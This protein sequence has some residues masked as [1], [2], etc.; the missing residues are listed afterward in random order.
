MINTISYN[1]VNYTDDTI[2][3]AQLARDTALNCRALNVDTMT[4]TVQS[5]SDLSVFTQNAPIFFLRGRSNYAAWRLKSITRE[6]SDLWTLSMQSP[7]GRLAQLPHRGGIYNGVTATSIIGEI[8]SGVGV[9]WLIDT[10]LE[11]VALYGY[12]PY[13]SPSGENGAMSGSAKDNLLK[14]LF[15]LNASLWCN[16]AGMMIVGSLPATA[17]STIDA[18]R[19]YR[20]NARVIYDAPVTSVTVLEHQYISGGE[21]TTLFDGVTTADQTIV[22]R[23]PMSDLSATGFNVLESGANYAIVSAGTG[24]LTGHKYVHTTREVTRSVTTASAPNEVRVEDATLVSITNSSVV[25]DRLADYYSHR[26]R[27]ECDVV[28]G[29]ESPGDVVNIYD[30]YDR[31]MRSACLESISPITVSQTLKGRVSALVGFTPW[32]TQQFEDVHQLIVTSGLVTIPSNATNITAV[33]IGGGNGG[34]SGGDGSPGGASVSYGSHGYELGVAG[35]A[36]A[37]GAGGA[38][39]KILRVTLTPGDYTLTIGSGGL[40]GTANGT[41][42]QPGGSGSDTTLTHQTIGTIYSTANGASASAGYTDPVDGSTYAAEG[43]SGI[44]GGHGGSRLSLDSTNNGQDV[45]YN[46][47]TWSGGVSAGITRQY[48]QDSSVV[49]II[50]YG[51]GGGGAAV[52]NNG[53]DAVVG[54]TA[55]GAKGANAIQPPVVTIPGSGGNGGNGGGGGGGAGVDR[56]YDGWYN[57]Y[58]GGDGGTGSNGGDGVDGCVILYYRVPIV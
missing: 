6:S 18:D 37:G 11:R 41:S 16:P 40:G 32:Q 33:L 46:G 29:F 50:Y 49:R 19:I 20:D 22:F 25:A 45:N 10:A 14:V 1:G 55:N 3:I 43:A 5:S 53:V 54:Y 30:P 23:E 56:E 15:A 4:A 26:T 48:Y 8:M 51:G 38:G 44:Q 2:K 13:V 34:Y 42:P 21:L 12:L 57:S 39:G 36:G 7:I 24:T 47:T 27:I 52:G 58:S 31:V 9:S 35:Y 17:A 28:L